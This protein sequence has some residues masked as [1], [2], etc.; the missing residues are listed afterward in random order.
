MK[1][2]IC[3]IAVAALAVAA[4][5]FEAGAYCRGCAIEAGKPAMASAAAAKPGAQS[6]EALP[7]APA[8]LMPEGADAMG[9]AACRTEERRVFA[10]GGYRLS[11]VEICE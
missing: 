11:A 5:S 3:T 8:Q 10:E 6:A 2:T 4:F 1:S 7:P 9:R